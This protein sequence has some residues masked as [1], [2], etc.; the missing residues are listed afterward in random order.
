MANSLYSFYIGAS[1]PHVIYNELFFNNLTLES[2][3][4]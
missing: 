1:S 4:L 3:G 2:T